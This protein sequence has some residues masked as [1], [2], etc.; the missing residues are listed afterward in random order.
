MTDPFA[1]MVNI[2]GLLTAFYRQD[3]DVSALVGDNVYTTL[4]NGFADWPAVRVVRI[5]GTPVQ[6]SHIDRP[7]VQIDC[8]GGPK[9]TAWK[10][11]ET[12]RAATAARLPGR[13]PLGY[14]YGGY[15]M[16]IGALQYQPDQ[17][18]D[19]A[20]PRY[21]FDMTLMTRPAREG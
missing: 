18:Y 5:G 8:W 2:E 11:A 14:V 6:V 17:D 4:P 7:L 1:L 19:P 9:A 10:V 12:L 13:H 20:K 21:L 3:P 16:R 15:G